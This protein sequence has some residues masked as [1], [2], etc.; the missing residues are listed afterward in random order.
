MILIPSPTDEENRRGVVTVLEEKG[1]IREGVEE[2][3]KEKWL[4]PSASARGDASVVK[5]KRRREEEEEREER[6]EEKRERRLRLGLQLE[7]E[8]EEERKEATARVATP[9]FPTRGNR[10]G[11]VCRGRRGEEEKKKKRKKRKGRRGCCCGSCSWERRRGRKKRR[12]GRREG[13]TAEAEREGKEEEQRRKKRLQLGEAK[14]DKVRTERGLLSSAFCRGGVSV[15]KGK[16]IKREREEGRKRR[17]QCYA[18]LTRKQSSYASRG[19]REGEEEERKEEKRGRRLQL[20]LRLG[21]RKER[22]SRRGKRR[23]DYH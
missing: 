11:A 19:R 23:R 10:G 2:E 22:K 13:A 6:E 17:E 1:R 3:K 12:R 14:E 5:G 4:C 18:F 7:E 15:E 9:L 20:G 21:E 16:R 8:E